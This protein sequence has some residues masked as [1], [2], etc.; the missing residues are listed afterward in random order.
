MDLSTFEIEN[1]SHEEPLAFQTRNGSQADPFAFQIRNGSQVDPGLHILLLWSP[2]TCCIFSLFT[3]TVKPLFLWFCVY[4]FLLFTAYV[5]SF[6]IWT[7]FL[8]L[9]FLHLIREIKYLLHMFF[10]E[11]RLFYTVYMSR[12]LDHGIYT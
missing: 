9:F 10:T 8:F 5:H 11:I 6:I 3:I 4:A 2:S 7:Y 1:G 12:K